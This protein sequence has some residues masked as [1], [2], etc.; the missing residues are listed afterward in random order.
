MFGLLNLVTVVD[1]CVPNIH[2]TGK[3]WRHTMT[4]F[5]LLKLVTAVNTCVPNIHVTGKVWRHTIQIA[6]VSV[7]GLC[8]G[9]LRAEHAR[10]GPILAEH[11]VDI[12]PVV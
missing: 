12:H 1:P 5:G 8:G 6:L 9:P 3:V 7:I 10:H 4:M 11:L 2:A